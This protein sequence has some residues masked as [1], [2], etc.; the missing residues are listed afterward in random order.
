M[1]HLCDRG[2]FL[3]AHR[4][5]QQAGSL[6]S[7][8]GTSERL[9][10]RPAGDQPCRA[11]A[12]PLADARGLA[13]RAVEHRSPVLQRPPHLSPARPILGMAL[14]EPDGRTGPRRRKQSI[15]RTGLPSAAPPPRPCATFSVAESLI[16]AAP[17]NW[18]R[19]APMR[20]SV[21]PACWNAKTAFAEA[22][23]AAQ[24][25]VAADPNYV[26]AVE[27]TSHLLTLLDRDDEAIVLLTEASR[28]FESGSLLAMLHVYQMELKQFDAARR[29]ARP[30]GRVLAAGGKGVCQ[31]AGMPAFGAGLPRGRLRGGHPPCRGLEARVLQGRGRT[32]RDP[33]RQAA[34]RIELPVGFVRQHRVTCVPATLSA[35]SRFWSKPADHVQVAE[36]ICYNGTSDYNERQWA[37]RNGWIAR[38]F[39]VTEDA[40]RRSMERG[41]PFTLNTVEP[42]AGPFAGGDRVRRPPRNVADSRASSRVS[43]EAMAD[44]ILHRYRAFG[45]RGMALVPVEQAARLEGVA[46]PDAELWD[47]I[48]AF[49]GA[50]VNHRRDE[51]GKDPPAVARGGA[52]APRHPRRPAAAGGLR[53]QHRRTA[54]GGQV[55]AGDRADDP[56]LQMDQLGLPPRL[57]R[58]DAAAGDLREDM[59]RRPSAPGLLA[60]VRGRAA[61]RRAA[62]SPRRAVRPAGPF[63]L[64]PPTAATIRCWQ[65]SIGTSGVSPRPWSFI[66]LP[67]A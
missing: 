58:R 42:G 44:K 34:Q 9:A 51:A 17:S 27:C 28:R 62:A 41:V 13:G 23:E 32:A 65:T 4:A 15:V 36:E 40:A 3:Q 20:S 63:A 21:G 49:D 26:Q 56:C 31:V 53:R 38:E 29:D 43:V 59:C 14:D 8:T 54:G 19:K 7:W 46:L 50:L 35:I 6:I 2:L 18:R 52:G 45:P 10:G 37:C 30:L 47:Q 5:S 55:A 39:T 33:A 24:Q 60:A 22:L 12:G 16:W 25:V 11:D 64:C 66:V 67:P 57:S 61:G 48:H 1:P